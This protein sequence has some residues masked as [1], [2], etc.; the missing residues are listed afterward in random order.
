MMDKVYKE[1]SFPDI[2]TKM[3]GVCVYLK[4]LLEIP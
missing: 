1:A 2:N 4:C 3:K